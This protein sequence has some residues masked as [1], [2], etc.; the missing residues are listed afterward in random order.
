MQWTRNRSFSDS[1]GRIIQRR[2]HRVLRRRTRFAGRVGHLRNLGSFFARLRPC[3]GFGGRVLLA[4]HGGRRLRKGTSAPAASASAPGGR[5][6]T[7]LTLFSVFASRG[8]LRFFDRAP[9]LAPGGGV[10]RWNRRFGDLTPVESGVQVRRFE[11]TASILV[12]GLAAYFDVGRRAE[13]VQHT[14]LR[15]LFG[16]HQ[17]EELVAALVA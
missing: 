11:R 1:Y 2:A 15:L 16:L 7:W 9:A 4:R 8:Q 6:V 12:E 3:P 17:R 14:R 13:G 10:R 5:R